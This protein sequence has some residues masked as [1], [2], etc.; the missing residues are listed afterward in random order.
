MS[1]SAC[2][3]ICNDCHFFK[4]LCTGCFNVKGKPFWAKEATANGICQLFDCSVNQRG[5][6][7]CGDC[8]DL[9]CQMFLDLKDPNISQE[10]HEKSI[11]QRVKVLKGN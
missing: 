3:L 5:Y 8:I 11:E 6:R 10:E 9:P 1:I 4:N 7:N 2:G